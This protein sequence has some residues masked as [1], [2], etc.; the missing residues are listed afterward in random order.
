MI[1]F[2]SLALA[3]PLSYAIA[4]LLPAFDA[5]I[6]IL[7]SET[8]IIALGVATAGS[9]DPRIAILVG[10]AALGAFLGDNLTYQLGRWLGPAIERRVFASEKG[11]RRRAWAENALEHYGARIIIACP[12]S[13]RHQ[14]RKSLAAFGCAA[15]FGMPA[16]KGVTGAPSGAKN[17]FTGAPSRSFGKIAL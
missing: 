15:V 9:A 4:V 13:E 6:P 3:S 1:D 7:P 16:A 14:L 2:G 11:A 17:T 8:L 12:S 10:L 5:I